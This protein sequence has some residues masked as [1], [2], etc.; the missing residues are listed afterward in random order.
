MHH[1]TQ[2]IRLNEIIMKLFQ[3]FPVYFF[4][5][6]EYRNKNMVERINIIIKDLAVTNI[7]G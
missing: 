2:N 3:T 1:Y 4:Y 6:L 5:K 7:I